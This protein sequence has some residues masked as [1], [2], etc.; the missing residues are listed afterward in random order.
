MKK[1]QVF[2]DINESIQLFVDSLEDHK[3]PYRFKDLRVFVFILKSENSQVMMSELS[4]YLNITPA[5]VSQ[6]I[7][8]FENNGYVKRVR[9]EDDRRKVYIQVEEP[10]KEAILAEW[11]N[12]KIALM[13]F[14][15]YIGEEDTEAIHRILSKLK[16]FSKENQI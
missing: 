15:D 6:L 5:A 1:E 9:S 8:K 3:K 12:R 7:Q 4:D 14:M 13:R 16:D 11:E 2:N 10:V